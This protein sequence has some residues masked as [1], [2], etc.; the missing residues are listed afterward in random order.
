MMYYLCGDERQKLTSDSCRLHFYMLGMVSGDWHFWEG[1]IILGS[2]TKKRE[3]QAVPN[4]YNEQNDIS[5][6]SLRIQL[7]PK[8]IK[9]GN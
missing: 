9:K 1:G 3:K 4:K 5:R 6:S 2:G 7:C 8:K